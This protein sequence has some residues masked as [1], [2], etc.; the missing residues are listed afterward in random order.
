MVDYAIIGGG[1]IGNAIARELSLRGAGEINVLEKE[2]SL[3]LHSS[4]RN[5]GV[6]HSGIN[7]KPGSLKAKL[8]LSG[9]SMLR[10][11]CAENKVPYEECGTIV[12]ARNTEEKERL[13]RLHKMGEEAGGSGLRILSSKELVKREPYIIESTALL[14]P[15]G[16]IVDSKYLVRTIAKEAESRG[17]KYIFNCQVRDINDSSIITSLGSVKRPKHIINCA[18]LYADNVAQMMSEADDYMIVPFRGEYLEVNVPINSMVYQVP[19]FIHPF[20]GVHLTKTL[21]GKVLAGPNAM[22]SFGR[23]SYAKEFNFNERIDMITKPHFWK[24]ISKK[25]FIKTAYL[26]SKTSF[27]LG[28]FREEVE[29]ITNISITR[30]QPGRAGIRAQLVNKDGEMVDD[31]KIIYRNDATHILNAVSPGLTCS[32]AFASYVAGKI[33]NE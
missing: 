17:V 19:D 6:I 29:S 30:I 15:T 11:Y 28:K 31:F 16:A 33:L 21:E 2:N 24:M 9:S 23:E 10:N 20:L 14:S 18:G 3:A 22:L 26:N 8:C 12:I 5:S 1:I 32:L 13:H 7:Q 27:S 25:S 4:G